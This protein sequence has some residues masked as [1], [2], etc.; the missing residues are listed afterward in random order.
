M[1][2]AREIQAHYDQGLEA[3]CFRGG[4]GELEY[5]RTMAILARELP[6][7]PAIVLDVGGG[8]GVY[9]VPLAAAGYEVHLVDPVPL[10]VEQ[11]DEAASKAGTKLASAKV[12]DA[13][14]LTHEADSADSVLLLGPLYHLT[15]RAD[16][17]L[18]LH[19]VDLVNAPRVIENA[20]GQRRLARIDVGGDADI[21]DDLD[22][23]HVCLAFLSAPSK[24]GGATTK[25]RCKKS[26]ARPALSQ[27]IVALRATGGQEVCHCGDLRA[28]SLMPE[29]P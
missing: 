17:I 19:L 13:R 6:P 3:V 14:A 16:R 1:D 2:I 20:L 27:P 26:S 7:P 11:A 25:N 29:A 9:A 24:R 23:R 28:N 12:G 4:A 5:L 8:A 21:A 10:H 18:A 15:E 22:V